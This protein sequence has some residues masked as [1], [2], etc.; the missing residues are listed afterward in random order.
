MTEERSLAIAA[1]AM[2]QTDF[3]ELTPVGLKIHGRPSL[4]EW[5]DEGRK[6]LA[7]NKASQW[8]IGD[9]LVYGEGQGEYGE[10]YSQAIAET[11]IDYRRLA[12][13]AWVSR[14]YNF[15]VR[16][17]K[18]SWSHHRVAAPVPESQR[19]E[20][21]DKAEEEGW[22]KDTLRQNLQ[23]AGLLEHKEMAHVG[24][25]SGNN[26][27]YTPTDYIE[28]ARSV[29]AGIDLDPASSDIANKA[30]Q[31]TTYYTS[32]DDGLSF[33]WKGRVWMNPPYA[34]DLIGKFTCKLAEHFA[35]GDI[36]EAI[37]LVNNA[38]ETSW[39]QP[40]L[41]QCEAVCFPRGRIK[42]IDTDGVASGAPLQGQAI[43]YLGK[44]PQ[45]FDNEFSAFGP[46]LYARRPRQ[47]S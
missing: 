12:D 7:I 5:L 4:A 21:L 15:S 8:A 10:C 27:W 14:Q 37:V 25:N 28:A 46:V 47:D 13:Y 39:F 18:L 6:L 45:L 34:A 9:W 11:D 36:T 31:A 40:L 41:M 19:G 24:H 33:Q 32:E 1:E 20:W 44:A 29:M 30:V 16:T 17:E 38:T 35:T 2:V 26:E 23:D 3:F 43:L 22:S 42:F